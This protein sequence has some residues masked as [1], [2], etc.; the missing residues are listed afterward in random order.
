MVPYD[1]G[2]PIAGDGFYSLRE[3]PFD[4]A[5]IQCLL[6]DSARRTTQIHPFHNDRLRIN[7]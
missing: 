6:K 2:V 3:G 1:K 4:P 7:G 5:V